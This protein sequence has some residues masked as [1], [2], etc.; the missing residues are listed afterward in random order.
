MDGTV[1][2]GEFASLIGVS[3]GRVSQYLTEG[4]I[5][6]AALVGVGRSA[7]IHVERAKADLRLK[8]DISQRLGNGI[9]T[10]LEP[11]ATYQVQPVSGTASRVAGLQQDLP[12]VARNDPDHQIK[13]QK[14]EQLQRANRNGAI[15]E[16]RDRGQLIDTL[17][18]R[19]ELGK[20]A[21][22]ML[23]IFEG[24]LTDLATAAASE[25]KVPQ[26]D[27]V[28]LFRKEFRQVR[29]KATR[30]LQAQLVAMP[31]TVDTA[32]DSDDIESLN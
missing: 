11:D 12:E 23:Q 19:A 31:E 9:D 14:L 22:A 27:A 18:A 17:E 30:M 29:A 15:A 4:K 6:G 10:R 8:L 24:A 7:R 28:H 32:L 25:F 3:A 5:S 20:I 2:K 16:A 13:M 1:T 26:R 21:T